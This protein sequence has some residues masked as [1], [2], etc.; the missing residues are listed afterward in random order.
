MSYTK[1]DDITAEAGEVVVQLDDGALV[2]VKCVRSVIINTAISYTATARALDA[3]AE[4]ITGSD[5]AAVATTF[6]HV[7]AA[8]IA[9]ART[10]EIAKDCLLVVLG[11]IPSVIQQTDVVKAASI[12]RAL[13]LATITAGVVDAA[14]AL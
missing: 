9:S 12:R 14:A 10:D 6:Q 11:E 13:A 1:R 2:A 5:G 7:D 8:S 3:N 4:A